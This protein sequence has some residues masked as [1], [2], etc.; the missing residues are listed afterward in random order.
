MSERSRSVATLWP[1]GDKRPIVMRPCRTDELNNDK[2]DILDMVRKRIEERGIQPI[3]IR[4]AGVSKWSPGA[5]WRLSKG[6]YDNAI[7]IER[8]YQ[9]AVAVGLRR[10][11]TLPFAP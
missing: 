11:K 8:A 7:S 6:Y 1:Q 5:H 3:D 9:L 10:T 4:R 2:A